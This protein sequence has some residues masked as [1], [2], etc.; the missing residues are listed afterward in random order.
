[1]SAELATPATRHAPSRSRLRI[2]PG[3]PSRMSSLAF[4]VVVLLVLASG[5]VAALI[6]NTTLQ[7][8]SAELTQRQATVDALSHQEAALSS[9][10][11]TKSSA[12]ELQAAARRLGMVPDP[13]PA[14]IDL[15]TGKV[16]GTPH[17]VTG[18]ELPDLAGGAPVSAGHR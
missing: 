11:D 4:T 12:T 16:R 9:S 8:Q 7:G 15:R 5:L 3:A 6:L 1:M 10:V 14:F 2:L 18:D 13:Q 17:Q